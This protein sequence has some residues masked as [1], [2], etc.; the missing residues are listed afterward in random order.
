MTTAVSTASTP[1]RKHL[2]TL[3]PGISEPQTHQMEAS[4]LQLGVPLPVQA[5]YT[6][7]QQGWLWSV[8]DICREARKQAGL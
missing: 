4:S 8:A 2:L 5:S 3:E 7:A 1:S 6:A